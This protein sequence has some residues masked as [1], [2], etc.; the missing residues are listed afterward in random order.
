[1]RCFHCFR[2][3]A[4]IGRKTE[5]L[6]VVVEKTTSN[7]W[8][9]QSKAYQVECRNLFAREGVLR[10]G[11]RNSVAVC[12]TTLLQGCSA[13]TSRFHIH[14][15][16]R[17]CVCSSLFSPS[18]LRCLPTNHDRGCRNSRQGEIETMHTVSS[19]FPLQQRCGTQR[20]AACVREILKI[21]R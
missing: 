18:C 17:W 2:H 19:D 5:V 1:M 12:E 6:G 11:T 10:R 8:K 16:C 20:S 21:K 3:Q 4:N 7:G 13:K 9:C 14:L 15:R